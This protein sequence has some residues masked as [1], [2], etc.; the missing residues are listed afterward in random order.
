MQNGITV[1]GGHG[2]GI[3]NNQLFNPWS[4]Y[5][6][7]DM[8]ILIAD[9]LNHRIIEWKTGS[10]NSGHVI[11]GGNG[12][13]D[14][15]NQLSCPTDIFIDHRTDSLI[16]CDR[17]NRRIVRWPRHNGR[18]GEVLISDIDCI[19]L[20]IDN[21]GHIY[22]SDDKKHEVRRYESGATHGVRVAGG[23]GRGNRCDQLNEPRYIFVD[24]QG[25][26][27]VSDHGNH[28]VIMWPDGAECGHTVIGDQNN[29]K[30]SVNLYFPQGIV[31][32]QKGSV[33]VA[34]SGKH[35]I[36]R[37]SRGATE[38]QIIVG[39]QCKGTK[40]N[41]LNWPFG[42]CFDRHQNLYVVDVYNH[43]VQK[44]HLDP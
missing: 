38:P 28:R 16:I 40:P 6:D 5:I 23:N 31:V 11:A 27:Y 3:G 43:R 19:A 1:A 33:Y 9:Q 42:L 4:V 26:L 25:S 14:G 12:Q 44:F 2:H 21:D 41:E 24:Q 36:V 20:T 18:F 10:P 22:V 29:E 7:D 39:G 13:G 30:N 17:D 15:I 34:E 32:D 35:R 8:S 37:W